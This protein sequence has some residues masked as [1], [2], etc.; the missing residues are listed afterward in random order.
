MAK[1]IQPL[2]GEV[3]L[4]AF[5]LWGCYLRNLEDEKRVSRAF[6]FIC[7]YLEFVDFLHWTAFFKL[8]IFFSLLVHTFMILLIVYTCYLLYPVMLSFFILIIDSYITSIGLIFS[9]YTYV[10]TFILLYIMVKPGKELIIHLYVLFN[11]K[12]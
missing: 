11:F 8:F 3:L 5:S 4:T 9:R 10:Y 7:L 12:W 2:P 1:Y 6:I